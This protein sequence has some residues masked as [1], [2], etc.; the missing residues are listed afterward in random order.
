MIYLLVRAVASVALRLFY[1]VQVRG[2]PALPEGPLLFVGNHPNGLID[3]AL[4]FAVTPRRVTFLAK[5][6]LFRIPVLGWLIRGM[7]ALPVYRR[8]DDPTR[9]GGNDATLDTAA[10]ALVEGGAITIFPEGK[11][12][13]EPQLAALKTGAC[14]DRPQGGGP[15]RGGD[16]GPGGADVRAQAPLSQR[17][18]HRGRC[19]DRRAWGGEAVADR[20]ISR[21]IAAG[22]C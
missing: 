14:A 10:R 13:S 15:G 17:G 9:M 22:I 21:G 11:S 3:P 8:Q 12:H 7:G 4:V 16:G 2:A 20:C 1:R 6:P 5:A 19:A 18:V